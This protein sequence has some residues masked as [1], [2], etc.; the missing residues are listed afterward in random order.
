V[1]PQV[2]DLGPARCPEIDAADRGEARKTTAR[3]AFDAKDTDG[4]AALSPTAT[5][6]WIN[7]Y[8]VS[9]ARKNAA[10]ARVVDQ[11]DRCRGSVAAPADS[12]GAEPAGG[13]ARAS[14]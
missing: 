4:T 9:E 10:L 13:R 3:P 12:A 14:G 11:H 6:K 7:A 8:D 1:V 5:R 2:V